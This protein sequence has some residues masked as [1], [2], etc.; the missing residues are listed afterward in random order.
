MN[1]A[2]PVNFSL[3]SI[4]IGVVCIVGAQVILMALQSVVA[5]PFT[6]FTQ[7]SLATA[8]GVVAWFYAGTKLGA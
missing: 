2:S 7:Q 3:K 6:Q 4:A 8:V 5:L 1:N